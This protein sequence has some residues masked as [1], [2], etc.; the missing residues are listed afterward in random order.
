MKKADLNA[1]ISNQGAIRQ[2]KMQLIEDTLLENVS[3]ARGAFGELPIC[4]C[5]QFCE[6]DPP[7]DLTENR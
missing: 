4:M 6:L 2:E 5:W 1:E 7:K 3:G